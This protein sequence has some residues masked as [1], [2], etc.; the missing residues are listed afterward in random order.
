MN[1]ERKRGPFDEQFEAGFVPMDEPP[2]FG[3]RAYRQWKDAGGKVDAEKQSA[4]A[5]AKSMEQA[6]EVVEFLGGWFDRREAEMQA[7]LLE[8][9]EE[10]RSAERRSI[11]F[12]IA[13]SVILVG[14][15]VATLWLRLVDGE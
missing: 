8:R 10:M 6:K 14:Q 7:R 11:F 4:A 9:M 5:Q 12:F 1:E 15:V 2:G 13:C 3:E